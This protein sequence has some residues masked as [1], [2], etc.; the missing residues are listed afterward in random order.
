[1][2]DLVR[3]ELQAP[4]A[5]LTLNRADKRNALNRDLIASTR[6]AFLR[7]R[8]DAAARCVILPAAG[9]VF[10]AGMDLG[11]L[12]ESVEV[13]SAGDRVWDDAQKLA[14]VYDLIYALPKPTIAA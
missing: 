5:I 13:G 1:M 8:D 10:C 2:S 4:A 14:E 12:R 3:Y 11:E 9:P 7:A 6:A